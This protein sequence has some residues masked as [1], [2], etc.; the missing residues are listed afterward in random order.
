MKLKLAFLLFSEK[1]VPNQKDTRPSA[2]YILRTRN[3]PPP[4][5][6]QSNQLAT[7]HKKGCTFFTRC[8]LF[9]IPY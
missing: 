8:S 3:F 7:L 2:E 1:K 9:A 6:W 4:F 5:A